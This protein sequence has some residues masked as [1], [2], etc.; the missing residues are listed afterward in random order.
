MT[1]LTHL[2]VRDA[3]EHVIISSEI[4]VRK[5]AAR[6]FRVAAQRFNVEAERDFARGRRV[7]RLTLLGRGQPGWMALLVDHK[8]AKLS[9]ILSFLCSRWRRQPERHLEKRESW[10]SLHASTGIKKAL[11]MRPERQR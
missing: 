1:F 6:I 4:G 2:G 5:P 3:F 7:W 11:Y 8:I 10:L 9:S